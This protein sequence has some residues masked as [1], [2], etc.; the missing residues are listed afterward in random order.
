MVGGSWLI[1]VRYLNT[2]LGLERAQLAVLLR[3]NMCVW[4]HVLLCHCLYFP[5]THAP[6]PRPFLSA[7]VISCTVSQTRC[8]VNWATGWS[9][10][11]DV[12]LT[13]QHHKHDAAGL[14]ASVSV[15]R[16]RVCA[17]V[18][19]CAYLSVV[20]LTGRRLGACVS[21]QT[22]TMAVF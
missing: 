21:L 2:S 5:F 3:G 14:V 16:S 12:A 13:T 8:T 18:F 19:V 7:C 1:T 4:V 15:G 20:W 22:F 17:G 9:T 11:P 6:R 10:A